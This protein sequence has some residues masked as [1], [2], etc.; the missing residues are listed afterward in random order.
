[1]QE[2]ELDKMVNGEAARQATEDGTIIDNST[3]AQQTSDAGTTTTETGTEGAAATT[4]TTTTDTSTD[5]KAVSDLLTADQLQILDRMS[6]GKVKTVEDFTSLLT[7]A[8]QTDVLSGKVKEFESKLA[9]SPFA[10][11]YEAK[12]NELKKAGASKDTLKAFETVNE[13][14]DLKAMDPK[15]A[16]I[17]KMVLVDGIGEKVARAKVEKLH[18]HSGLYDIDLEVAESDLVQEGKKAIE[19]LSAFKTQVS[20]PNADKVILDEAGKQAL[21]AQLNPFLEKINTGYDKLMSVV[22]PGENGGKESNFDLTLDADSKTFITDKIREIVLEEN[23]PLTTENLQWAQR[24]AVKEY[25]MLHLGTIVKN[26][27]T[28]QKMQLDKYYSE[29]YENTGGKL[30][31]D[32][33]PVQQQQKNDAEYKA[34]EN[35]MLGVRNN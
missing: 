21:T 19:E 30:Q 11:E 31:G 25:T 22:L 7:K 35:E 18:D 12:R 28:T 4:A 5:N 24:E 6:G 26:T 32:L 33:S 27:L 16:L 3:T 17:M 13:L 1:M 23:L 9:V 34:F 14:G 20:T 10:D 8:E 29:K 2:D 15:E